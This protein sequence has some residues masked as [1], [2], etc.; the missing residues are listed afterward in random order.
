MNYTKDELIA[1]LLSREIRDGDVVFQG[2]AS[3]LALVGIELARRTHAKNLTYLS[4]W[5]VDPEY[6]TMEKLMRY[7]AVKVGGYMELTELWDWIQSGKVDLE[8][9]RPAQIDREGNINN[10]V[11]GDYDSPKVRLP[12]GIAIGDV[13]CLIRRIVLY[14]TRHLRRTFIEKVDFITARGPGK[15]RISYNYGEG[16]I[17]II[18]PLCVFCFDGKMRV[19]SIHEGVRE[20]E[21]RENTGFDIDIDVEHRTPPPREEEIRMIREIDPYGFRRLEFPEERPKVIAKIAE[22]MK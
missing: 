5:G 16:P 19:L 13:C 21:V 12:G 11:I 7:E 1:V 10:T 3:P 22:L 2:A 14:V 4:L 8:F 18:T 17:K 9:L 20:E 15:W 6:I